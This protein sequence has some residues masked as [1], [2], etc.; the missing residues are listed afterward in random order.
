MTNRQVAMVLAVIVTYF[1]K[2]VDSPGL[3]TDI[4]DFFLEWL[5]K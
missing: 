3:L 5:E 4:A 1:T 2:T